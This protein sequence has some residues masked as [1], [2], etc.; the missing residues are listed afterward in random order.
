[1]ASLAECSLTMA[2]AMDRQAAAAQLVALSKTLRNLKEA[3]A[4]MDMIECVEEQIREAMTLKRPRVS[5]GS[6]NWAEVDEDEAPPA[7]E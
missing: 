3:C 6:E 2:K 7:S 1:M 5:S 4:L